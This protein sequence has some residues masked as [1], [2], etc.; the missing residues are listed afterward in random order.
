MSVA[1]SRARRSERG[2]AL[3][4]VLW[5]G[6]LFVIV[7]AAFAFAMRTELDAARNFKDEAEAYALAQAGVA[8]GLAELAE[9]AARRSTTPFRSWSSG[10]VSMGRGGYESVIAD[11]E[12]KLSLNGASADSLARLLRATGV[13]D[14]GVAATIVDSILDW[15][16]ADNLHRLNGAENEYYGA[17]AVP[18][19]TRN[20]EFQA[21]EELL[22]VRGMTREIF[23]GTIT[24]PEQ[25]AALQR[26]RPADRRL[27]P[28]QYLGI[29]PFLTVLT[30]G[31]V[32]P[33]TAS[34]DVRA[35]LA[36]PDP[37]AAAPGPGLTSRTYTIESIGR[38]EGSPSVYRIVATVE[39]EGTPERPRLR[40]V[41]WREGPE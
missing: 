13:A 30:G 2:A 12:G 29:R 38:V 21:L 23:Y 28:G 37:G 11:E 1:I 6:A 19:R 8:R 34:A 3:L 39:R 15:T 26:M 4:L 14:P 41:A 17:L 31:R 24:E 36:L 32:N 7:L 16:D 10:R 22:L 35:A 27:Q 20:G 25:R 5:L 33:V 9:A 18:Y 40:V